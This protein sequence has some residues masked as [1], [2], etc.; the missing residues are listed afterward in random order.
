MRQTANGAHRTA[1]SSWKKFRNAYDL[2]LG[3][4]A[5]PVKHKD[6]ELRINFPLFHSRHTSLP[7]STRRALPISL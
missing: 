4:A 5:N 3:K 2:R 1:R 6:G 7:G